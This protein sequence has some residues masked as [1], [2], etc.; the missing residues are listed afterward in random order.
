MKDTFWPLII[1]ALFYTA[2]PQSHDTW[3]GAVGT[4]V[5]YKCLRSCVFIFLI[6]PVPRLYSIDSGG[7]Y[8][9]KFPL[10]DSAPDK[11]VCNR[12]YEVSDWDEATALR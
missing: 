4:F 11:E 12:V 7:T 3:P 8:P 10:M 1:Y 9:Q 5:M 6:D 2:T